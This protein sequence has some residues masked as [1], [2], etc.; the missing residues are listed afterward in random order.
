MVLTP[1]SFGN[2]FLA[3]I[4][5]FEILDWMY[6][7]KFAPG[8]LLI[9]GKRSPACVFLRI[10]W[11]FTFDSSWA[12]L[13]VQKCWLNSANTEGSCIIKAKSVTVRMVLINSKA[14]VVPLCVHFK[15]LVVHWDG[16]QMRHYLSLAEG[17]LWH[18]LFKEDKREEF[19]ANDSG[20]IRSY[21][22]EDVGQLVCL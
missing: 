13:Q 11:V 3:I 15:M 1:K 20:W 12:S 2:S 5:M 18:M 17:Q 4:T 8:E 6:T 14:L 10:T 9:L 22:M 19:S 21:F 16:S 7:Y